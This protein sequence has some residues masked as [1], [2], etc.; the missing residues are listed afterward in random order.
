MPKDGS[1]IIDQ[2]SA[3]TKLR[4]LADFMTELDA[5]FLDLQFLMKFY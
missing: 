1:I 2:L 4:T 3:A 5:D